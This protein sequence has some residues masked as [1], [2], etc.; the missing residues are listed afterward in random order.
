M[1]AKGLGQG[2]KKKINKGEGGTK[3][4]RENGGKKEKRG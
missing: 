3:L 1:L 4:Q 2:R